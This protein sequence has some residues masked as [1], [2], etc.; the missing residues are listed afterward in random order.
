ML[1]F[2][3]GIITT[4]LIGMQ[5]AMLIIAYHCFKWLRLFIIA[6]IKDVESE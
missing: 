3:L 2:V 4:I 5:I 1:G 6:Y